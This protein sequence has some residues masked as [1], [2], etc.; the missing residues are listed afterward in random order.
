MASMRIL[1]SKTHPNVI[2]LQETLVAAEKERNF[3]Y[4]LRPEWM[5]CAVSSVGKSGGTS[6][7]LGS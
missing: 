2:F 4:I 5:I 3:M 7:V 1:L 6:S